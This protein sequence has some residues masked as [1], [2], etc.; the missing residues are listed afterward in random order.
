MSYKLGE[1]D[2]Q[3]RQKQSPGIENVLV[4]QGGGSLGAFP[5]GII[6]AVKRQNIQIDIV[7][8]TSIGVVNAAIIV[9]SKSPNPETDLENFCS[10]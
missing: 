7:A 5:C 6:K 1:Y 8:E 4:M 3:D 10:G 9:C 2:S